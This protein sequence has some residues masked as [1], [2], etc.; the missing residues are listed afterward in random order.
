MAAAAAESPSPGCWAEVIGTWVVTP[1]VFVCGELLPKNL[2]YLAP[3][4]FLR[5]FAAP[6]RVIYWLLLPVTVPPAGGITIGSSQSPGGGV[7][8]SAKSPCA[9]LKPSTITK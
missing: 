3:S 1:V 9:P 2:C 4:H 7:I 8:V 5:R 6:F